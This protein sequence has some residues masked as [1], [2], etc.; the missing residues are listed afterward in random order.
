M[1]KVSVL[2]GSL[3]EGSINRKFALALG[4]LAENR[5][6]FDYPDLD[7]PLYNEDLWEALPESVMKLK[8]SLDAA[9]AILFV[10]PEYNRAFTPAIKNA[11]DWGSRPRGK[12]S[13]P[14]KPAG[15]V[16][17]SP[18]KIGTAVSQALLRSVAG[19]VGL[20]VMG[21]PEIN[22]QYTQDLIDEDGTITNASTAEF[23]AGYVA[24]FATFIERVSG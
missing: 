18:G 19:H 4:K 21:Q 24:K 10:T 16:G 6:E 20:I 14:G 15:I 17:A 2:I 9:D 5:L 23:V 3:R 1:H 7:L 12:S 13:W 8:S 11:I 22:L